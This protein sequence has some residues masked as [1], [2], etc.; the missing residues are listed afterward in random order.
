MSKPQ[1]LNLSRNSGVVNFMSFVKTVCNAV[2]NLHGVKLKGHTFDESKGENQTF[3]VKEDTILRLNGKNV[4][5]K[6]YQ[7]RMNT[8]IPNAELFSLA[9][10][11]VRPA[12]ETFAGR[13]VFTVDD[14]FHE[15]SEEIGY[16]VLSENGRAILVPTGQSAGSNT[17]K[18]NVSLGRKL[19][20]VGKI[21]NFMEVSR[22][23][24][25]KLNLRNDR[26]MGPVI[27]LIEE[28][29]ATARKNV[30]RAEDH[31]IWQG[32]SFDDS[33]ETNEIP[34]FFDSFS[35]N[36]SEYEGNNPSKGKREV[37]AF[38]SGGAV[39]AD[40]YWA[41][42]TADE[43]ITD[44]RTGFKYV[45][46]NGVYMPN[47]MAI[48]H[49][50]LID[51]ALKRTSDTDSTPIMEWLKR[52]IQAAFK[53]DMNIVASNALTNFANTDLSGGFALL[54]SQKKYQAIS[55]VEA[56]TVLPAKEDA[57]G[58]IRQFVT[59]KTGGTLV[60]HPSAAYLGIGISNNA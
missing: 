19:N 42:K 12:D 31:I 58:T 33:A 25:Q 41:N 56:I 27:S 57:D 38:N 2:E 52:A 30:L 51:I 36:A 29:L 1:T 44:V 5:V 20:P 11:L 46:R 37:V 59:M 23:E 4:N 48:D 28:K 47:T 55:G 32:G 26:G 10:E 45:R 3:E 54:D 16:D 18:A 60:K 17:P 24:L 43:I 50:V 13:D 39:A 21:Q 14:S 22:D 9:Q 34:G 49:Q 6:G 35:T 7:V 40:R 8:T 53:V 15:G